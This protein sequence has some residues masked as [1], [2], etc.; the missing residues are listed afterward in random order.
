VSSKEA[1]NKSK[2]SQESVQLIEQIV[3]LGTR[4]MQQEE[5]RDRERLLLLRKTKGQA[6][7]DL[8]QSMTIAALHVLEA[9]GQHEPIN[10]IHIAKEVEITKG[11]VSKIARKLLDQQLIVAERLPGNKKDLYFRLTGKGQEIFHWHQSLHEELEGQVKQ[12]LRRYSLDELRL[13]ARFMWD[14]VGRGQ[15]E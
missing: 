10:G 14:Y 15:S 2:Q 12:F 4:M 7:A 1:E 3:Q 5:E 8:L 6:F 13:I 11:A 9:I